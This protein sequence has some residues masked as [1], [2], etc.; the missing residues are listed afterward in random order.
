MA[1]KK[2]TLE[3]VAASVRAK[4]RTRG[5]PGNP[6]RGG[7]VLPMPAE[8]GYRGAPIPKG[9]PLGKVPQVPPPGRDGRR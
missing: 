1:A 3:Q 5:A 8:F 7:D 2:P 4:R 6:P 9:T